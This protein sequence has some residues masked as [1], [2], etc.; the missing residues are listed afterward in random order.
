M[1]LSLIGLIVFQ[2]YWIKKIGKEKGEEFDR[3]INATLA[4]VSNNLKDEEAFIFIRN[5]QGPGFSEVVKEQIVEKGGQSQVVVQY[6]TSTNH[7][8]GEEHKDS[9]PSFSRRLGPQRSKWIDSIVLNTQNNSHYKVITAIDTTINL[10]V[11]NRFLKE[12]NVLSERINEMAMQYAFEEKD[13]KTRLEGINLDSIITASLSLQGIKQLSYRYAIIDSS[14]KLL[15][16][17]KAVLEEKQNVYS[18]PIFKKSG[19]EGQLLFL[20]EQRTNYIL[21]S[22]GLNVFA[23]LFLTSVLLSTFAY[24]LYA[25]FRQ[26]KLAQIKAD[27]INNMTHEFKTPVATISLAI[28]SMLHPNVKKNET[29]LDYFGQIIKKENQRINHQI[30]RL[31]EMAMFDRQE[32]KMEIQKLNVHETIKELYRDFELRTRLESG[33]I[34]LNLIATNPLILGDPMHFYNALRNLID[35]GIKYSETPF[36]IEIN[37]LNKNQLLYIEVIDHGIGM[38]KETQKRAFDRFYRKTEG[39]IHTTKGFGLGLAYVKE[40]IDRLKGSIEIKSKPGEGSCFIITIPQ[41][42]SDS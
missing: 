16:G 17:S 1:S 37:T 18:I 4:Q 25:I 3:N 14:K 12:K 15:K 13:L 11:I 24:T 27:L 2:A 10:K 29:E 32:L 40:I 19:S 21:R 41:H 20:V 35:N 7:S 30:E 28:D 26:K 42:E 22:I 8:T 23:A 39:N 36:K 33:T 34:H 5:M 38:S 31:L 9:F 6:T